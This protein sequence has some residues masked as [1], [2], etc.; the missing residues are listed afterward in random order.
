[1]EHQSCVRPGQ[2][3][4]GQNRQRGCSQILAE[5]WQCFEQDETP[6]NLSF[7][8]ILVVV[9]SLG[10]G[11][12]GGWGRKTPGRLVWKAGRHEELA[13]GHGDGAERGELDAA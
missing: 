4:D 6:S 8:V 13:R 1:M 2:S 11:A 12:G 3:R 9:P 5:G 7:R 10:G